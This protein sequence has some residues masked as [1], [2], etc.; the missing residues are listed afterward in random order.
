M[1][2]ALARVVHA[3]L[4]TDPRDRPADAA[5][6]RRLLRLAA[7]EDG[8]ALPERLEPLGVPASAG[9]LRTPTPGATPPATTSD[10]GMAWPRRFAVACLAGGLLAGGLAAGAWLAPDGGATDAGAGTRVPGDVVTV[11]AGPGGDV[12]QQQLAKD[13]GDSARSQDDPA[14]RPQG[15]TGPTTAPAVLPPVPSGGGSG[16]G[17]GG[18]A[19][20]RPGRRRSRR[21][22]PTTPTATATDDGDGGE[23]SGPGK[24]PK[25]KPPKPTKGPGGGDAGTQ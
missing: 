17:S 18:T 15:D 22:F 4:A 14:T 7:V 3:C 19:G 23:N 12:R 11:T 24:G 20:R 5:T 9:L 21:S 25:A 13:G 1:P 8:L 2:P 16:E 10:D 6:V